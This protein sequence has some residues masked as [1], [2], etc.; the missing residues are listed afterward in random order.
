MPN[1]N[2]V[3]QFRTLYLW[4]T[5]NWILITGKHSNQMSCQVALRWRSLMIIYCPFYSQVVICKKKFSISFFIIAS[6]NASIVE[7]CTDLLWI[8]PSKYIIFQHYYLLYS[9]FF[10]NRWLVLKDTYMAY[11]RPEDGK[12]SDVMLMDRKFSVESGMRDTGAHHGLLIKN[13]NR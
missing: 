1:V 7:L 8:N 12:V 3:L 2:L 4:V 13:L 11:V 10:L 6:S 5:I 9:M